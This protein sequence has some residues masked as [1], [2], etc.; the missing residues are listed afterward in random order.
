[1]SNTN[2]G[3]KITVKDLTVI[4]KNNHNQISAIENFSFEVK[5]GGFTSLLGTSGCGKSTI[6]NVIAGFICPTKGEVLLNDRPIEEPSKEKGIVFQNYSLFPWKTVKGNIEFGLRMSNKDKQERES[7][8]NEY[9][10]KI[11][12]SS[13]EARYPHELSG[14]MAQRVAIA[15]ALVND[16]AVLLM[17][18][19][20]GALDAQTRIMMQ[21]LLL[22]I[23]RDFSKTIIFVTHDVEEAIFLSDQIIIMTASPGKVKEVFSVNIEKPKHFE[24]IFESKEYSILRKKCTDIIR[25]ETIKTLK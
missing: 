7:I 15:R 22:N 11:G 20:F 9:V 1:M 21:E 18:E 24:E 16:P 25:E 6:L 19:P 3:G 10:K 23:W 2:K 14:G 13:F 4:Y 17:D 12:L 8:V 5:P